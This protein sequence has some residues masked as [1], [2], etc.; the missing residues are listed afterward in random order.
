MPV[1]LQIK[2]SENIFKPLFEDW[3]TEEELCK[4]WQVCTKVKDSLENGSRME[5]LSWRLWYLHQKMVKKKN[6]T[7]DDFKK[8]ISA[9]RKEKMLKIESDNEKIFET[10]KK[11]IETNQKNKNKL[12]SSI[13]KS[14]TP[15]DS[16][17]S[18]KT[19]PNSNMTFSNDANSI[20]GLNPSLLGINDN[21]LDNNQ[22][23]MDYMKMKTDGNNEIE[24]LSIPLNDTF[25]QNSNLLLPTD[26]PSHDDYTNITDLFSH[27]PTN[28]SVHI[29]QPPHLHIPDPSLRTEIS[30]M[31]LNN[32]FG[33]FDD[34]N[35][36][37]SLYDDGINNDDPAFNNIFNKLGAFASSPAITHHSSF[38][39]T[40]FPGL[41]QGQKLDLFNSSTDSL[42]NSLSFS[43]ASIP[44][45]NVSISLMNQLTSYNGL[46]STDLSS[47][48][49]LTTTPNLAALNQFPHTSPDLLGLNSLAG[50]SGLG[51][52]NDVSGSAALGLDNTN[53]FAS[54]LL[55]N[56]SL[57]S[58]SLPQTISTTNSGSLS[59]TLIDSTAAGKKTSNTATAAAAA[60]ASASTTST[61]KNTVNANNSLLSTIQDSIIIPVSSLGN[62]TPTA[63]SVALNDASSTSTP[64][65][66]N[67]NTLDLNTFNNQL[68]MKNIL[69]SNST[70]T[71][72]K[73]GST[74]TNLSN[75]L[76]IPYDLQ[77][78]TT[79][80]TTPSTTDKLKKPK[81][82]TL[83]NSTTDA[84][85]LNVK[86]NVS[87]KQEP[88]TP[89]T[90]N[91]NKT[92]TN[93]QM[94]KQE[95]LNR[96]ILTQ[97]NIPHANLTSEQAA[98]L[99]NQIN[100]LT[101]NNTLTTPKSDQLNKQP[102]S[103]T[104]TSLLNST[105][106]LNL[107]NT[108]NTVSPSLPKNNTKNKEDLNR[109]LESIKTTKANLLLNNTPSASLLSSLMPNLQS[110]ITANGKLPLRTDGVATGKT[111]ATPTTATSTPTTS[112]KIFPKTTTSTPT[113]SATIKNEKLTKNKS[114]KAT[115]P[116]ATSSTATN[117]TNPSS[118]QAVAAAAAAVAALTP[119]K[120]I[121]V[122]KSMQNTD[123]LTALQ[124][125]NSSTPTTSQQPSQQQMLQQSQLL[126]SNTK[127]KAAASLYINQ[128]TAAIDSMATQHVKP[129]CAN[130]GVNHTPLWRRSANDEI[131]CNACGLYQKL[132][133]VPRPKSIRQH[134]VRKDT[135]A[136]SEHE[137]TECSNCHT[138]NTPLWRRDENGA[139]LCNACG[140]YQKMHHSARPISM[141]TDLPRKRQRFDSIPNI[142][143][144]PNPGLLTNPGL[145]GFLP[146]SNLCYPMNFGPI[147][148]S[149]QFLYN[150]LGQPTLSP[151][152]SD[153][154]DKS[155]KSKKKAKTGQ[156]SS[157]PQ[158]KMK[159]STPTPPTVDKKK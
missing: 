43:T 90:N 89:V 65:S 111:T 85:K 23:L 117:L 79:T 112:D 140:L 20:D 55:T 8:K 124:K 91:K 60:S 147:P 156:T 103:T 150:P 49:D 53:N 54:S 101:N 58:P 35:L 118:A 68:L 34:I 6:I 151:A 63:H 45:D 9:I 80:P 37:N 108:P 66:L 136:L 99:V 130:C 96:Y 7:T 30:E 19:E 72:P 10:I 92:T 87:I 31:Y 127:K 69:K 134:A 41:T 13:V 2:G 16:L 131:L 1:I 144:L 38:K 142:P 18:V 82:E 73:L 146:Y 12:K 51:V 46:N 26:T 159:L 76:L 143:G 107:F 137:T 64:V 110:T 98:N 153:K 24:S 115:T 125:S 93:S 25:N 157:V 70:N 102:L 62:S 94:S 139:T 120:T 95:I 67:M 104:A 84:S 100:T 56:P 105:N 97:L 33:K 59:S 158:K 149:S 86:T 29:P 28:N 11:F 47:Y 17:K 22:I 74:N 138:T 148:G 40:S 52:L 44:D 116:V 78:T 133:K 71:T 114:K 141:K 32:K 3:D 81:Q 39:N 132:H 75:D 155:S 106:S 154:S 77:T 122:L 109:L 129:V 61:P 48:T 83:T 42:N 57:I 113:A 121:P 119:T 50:S 123:T 21:I 5:N 145:N 88:K 126:K 36:Y 27:F 4:A 152:L 135:Q 15:K 14:E 128:K